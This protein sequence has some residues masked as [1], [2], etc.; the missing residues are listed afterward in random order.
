MGHAVRGAGQPPPARD[1]SASAPPFQQ[2][3]ASRRR[4]APSSSATRGLQ[5]ADVWE[6]PPSA[7]TEPGANDLQRAWITSG[8]LS[9]AFVKSHGLQFAGLGVLHGVVLLCDL[10]GP[11]ALFQGVLLLQEQDQEG[12]DDDE[13]RRGLLIWLGRCCSPDCCARCCRPSCARSCRRPR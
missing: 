6:L 2:P 5:Q 1:P 9:L 11:Y 4:R 7:R 3:P 13:T 12:R 10:L 8:S